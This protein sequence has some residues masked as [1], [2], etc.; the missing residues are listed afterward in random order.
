MFSAEK[1]GENGVLAGGVTEW[2]KVAVLKTVVPQGT[3]GSNPSSSAL[4]TP[5]SINDSGVFDTDNGVGAFEHPKIGFPDSRDVPRFGFVFPADT[6]C[7]TAII[8]C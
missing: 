1:T 8:S 2:L 7:P 5:L 6:K 3:G 4:F